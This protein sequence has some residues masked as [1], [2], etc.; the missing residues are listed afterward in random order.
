MSQKDILWMVRNK[1]DNELSQ[2]L[3]IIRSQQARAFDSDNEKSIKRLQDM[4]NEVIQARLLKSGAKNRNPLSSMDISLAQE[5][6]KKIFPYATFLIKGG[7]IL[8]WKVPDGKKLPKI[9]EVQA[10][11]KTIYR[12]P[13]FGKKKNPLPARPLKKKNPSDGRMVYG[14][15]Y[16]RLNKLLK[17]NFKPGQH[18]KMQSAGKMD[19]VIETQQSNGR[20][21]QPGT[22][23]LLAHYYVQ[24]DDLMSD[25]VMEIG[26]YPE[27]QMAEALS[28]QHDPFAYQQ[29][30]PEPGK[31]NIRAKKELNS[32]LSS[33]LKTLVQDYGARGNPIFKWEDKAMETIKHQDNPIYQKVI[34]LLFEKSV[35]HDLV[36]EW[37]YP[38]MPH[39]Y[40]INSHLPD[41]IEKG[42]SKNMTAE[43]IFDDILAM[44]YREAENRKK[45]LQG[46]KHAG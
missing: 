45:K 32:F 6:L 42:I 14:K 43:Q 3:D 29:V 41:I 44:I 1:S 33:W 27:Y 2:Y 5:K 8:G 23:V 28:Y 4:E 25:P 40:R 19:L 7:K 31:V 34:N 21:N 39:T 26:V 11:I 12:F 30:Y 17:G 36:R 20:L 24:N 37:F 13:D 46:G 22:V 10:A 9:S 18:Y 15:I 35:R 16:D 38:D